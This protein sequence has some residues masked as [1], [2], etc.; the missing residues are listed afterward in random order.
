MVKIDFFEVLFTDVFQRRTTASCSRCP[1]WPCTG[2]TF[3]GS[4][5]I[6]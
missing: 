4:P 1:S 5:I 3:P 6:L 2:S